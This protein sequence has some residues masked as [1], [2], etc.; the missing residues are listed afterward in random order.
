MAPVSRKVNLSIEIQRPPPIVFATL[1]DL[2]NYGSWLPQSGVFKGTT[3][4]SDTPIR[5]GT[6]YIEHS[7]QGTRYGEVQALE[8]AER[9]VVFHQPMKLKPFILGLELDVVVEMF[10]KD[11]E[12][13]GCLLEREIRLQ[14]P[15]ILSLG[16]ST[17][18][19]MLK[20]K[21]VGL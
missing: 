19:N 21:V 18:A 8:E 5:T 12:G 10:A 17:I 16:A 7:P 13:D 20:E 14:I 11:R 4:V 9:H 3:E 1:V 15:S 2:P 6:K